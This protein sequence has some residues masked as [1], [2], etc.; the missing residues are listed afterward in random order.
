MLLARDRVI[1][2]GYFVRVEGSLG[3]ETPS[4]LLIVQS[5]NNLRGRREE[6]RILPRIVI[7]FFWGGGKVPWR[8]SM[9]VIRR[10]KET[11]LWLEDKQ[12]P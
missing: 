11:C 6:Q 9:T 8:V 1:L 5:T 2:I 4:F 10:C 7:A 12:C 3:A